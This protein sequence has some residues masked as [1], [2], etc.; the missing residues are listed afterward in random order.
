[1][2]K[3]K[4]LKKELDLIFII[5]REESYGHKDIDHLLPFI[6]FL[7]K[8]KKISFTAECLILENK[9]NYLKNLDPR[10]N[11]FLNLK[12]IDTKFLYQNIF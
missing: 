12:N 2:T 5:L 3:K 9:A 10:V 6:Y 8:I 7:S 4:I 11:M 1:M